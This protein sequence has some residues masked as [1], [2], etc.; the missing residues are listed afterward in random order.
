[1]ATVTVKGTPFHTFGNLPEKGIKAPDF[2]LV[3]TDLSEI[4]L[5]DYKGKKVILNIFTSIDTGTCAASVRRFNKEAQD[6]ENTVVLCI[7][8]DL[9]FA[10]NRF[11]SAE[12]LE[13]VVNASTF[14]SPGFGKDYGVQFIDGPLKGLM[15]RSIVIVDE[16]GTVTYTQQVP[17]NG[18]EPDYAS[19]LAA[20]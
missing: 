6:L 7:S 20:I 3:K 18:N 2:S 17:E 14:R 4:K 15:S 12:G 19:A 13:N 11:C 10:H 8:M 9:P 1:M 5:S 16:E